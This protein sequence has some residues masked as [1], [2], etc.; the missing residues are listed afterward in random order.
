V[1]AARLLLALV[2]ITP[3]ALYRKRNRGPA[4]IAAVVPGVPMATASP[5][6]E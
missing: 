1:V 5:V 3:G 6:Y 4:G 2:G